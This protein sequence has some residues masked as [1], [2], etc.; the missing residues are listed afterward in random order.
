MRS[1]FILSKYRQEHKPNHY[2]VGNQTQ[3]QLKTLYYNFF[4]FFWYGEISKY[5]QSVFIKKIL[6]NPL[7]FTGEVVT[8]D[9]EVMQ[10]REVQTENRTGKPVLL[11]QKRQEVGQT[12][13]RYW[14]LAGKIIVRQIE[15]VSWKRVSIN[16]ENSLEK[17]L[18][19]RKRSFVNV[20]Y[21]LL[22]A[23]GPIAFFTCIAHLYL[24][25]TLLVPHTCASYI[26]QW[27][28]FFH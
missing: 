9:V 23:L 16:D 14:N 19:E 13:D 24:Y 22:W 17:S 18:W 2:F 7:Y 15:M 12:V 28:I 6:S 5:A 10:M 25:Y 21:V 8:R 3:Y 27:C 26:R 4:F 11:E 1:S 20:Y